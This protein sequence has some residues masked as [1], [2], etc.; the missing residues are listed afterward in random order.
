MPNLYQCLTKF[1]NVLSGDVQALA[2]I[3]PDSDGDKRAGR[4]NRQ[5][6]A[7]ENGSNGL[8]GR[9]LPG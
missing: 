6:N 8:I 3:H 5:D 2:E 9:D 1:G 4:Y 7:Q